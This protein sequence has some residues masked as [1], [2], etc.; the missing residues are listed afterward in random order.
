[1]LYR[2]ELIQSNDMLRFLY[3]SYISFNPYQEK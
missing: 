3:I 1:M 2:K